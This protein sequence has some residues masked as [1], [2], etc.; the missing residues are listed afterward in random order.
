MTYHDRFYS[1]FLLTQI[2][3][4]GILPVTNERERHIS[5]ARQ[6]RETF[7]ELPL[8]PGG[9]LRSPAPQAFRRIGRVPTGLFPSEMCKMN[10]MIDPVTD[11]KLSETPSDH[12][13]DLLKEAAQV[14]VAVL[15]H[16]GGGANIR[17]HE[18]VLNCESRGV[19]AEV[20][21]SVDRAISGHRA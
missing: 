9:Q 18:R 11:L 19:L 7:L 17:I 5:K 4:L 13:E 3:R 6:A 2:L 16:D 1:V 15:I 10:A 20:C 14:T 21:A 12:I 8:A